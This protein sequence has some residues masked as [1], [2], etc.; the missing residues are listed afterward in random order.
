MSEARNHKLV[1]RQITG[2]GVN[3]VLGIE[4]HVILQCGMGLPESILR[5]HVLFHD[6]IDTRFT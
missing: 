5:P 4:L 3:A 2:G 1:G 6:C